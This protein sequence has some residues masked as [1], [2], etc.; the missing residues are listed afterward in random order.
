MTI[1]PTTLSLSGGAVIL[2][3]SSYIRDPTDGTLSPALVLELQGMILEQVKV[4]TLRS[5]TAP[6]EGKIRRKTQEGNADPFIISGATQRIGPSHG[7]AQSADAL[8][9][10]QSRGHYGALQGKTSGAILRRT[11][12][13]V[14][15]LTCLW[16]QLS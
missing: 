7:S 15:V 12:A 16:L 6:L 2:I 10:G 3:S 8:S 9:G 1:H 14:S 4:Q 13:E 11:K 5:F